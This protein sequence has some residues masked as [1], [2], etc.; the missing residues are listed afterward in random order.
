MSVSRCVCSY[1]HDLQVGTSNTD[2]DNGSKLLS[3]EALPLSAA[4]LLGELLHMLQNIVDTALD[5]HDIL[6]I[7]L[8]VPAAD[9]SQGRVIDSSVLGEVDLLAGEQS[10]ALLLDTSLLGELNQQVERLLGDKVLAEIKQNV[11]ARGALEGLGEFGEALG[12]GCESLLQNEGLSHRLVVL[13][14]SGPGREGSSLRH[15]VGIAVVVD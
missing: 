5:I 4:D 15:L 8:H 14:E 10:I 2:V 11:G 1:Y 7:N 3:S 9:I 12:I 6:A 13:L